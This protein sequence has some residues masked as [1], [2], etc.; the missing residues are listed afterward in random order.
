MF[1]LGINGSPRKKGNSQYLM[2]LF[3]R[4]MEGKGYETRVLDATKLDINAC[5]GC[6]TCEK[7][8]DC[9]FKDEFTTLFLPEVI[10][11]DII[12]ISSPVYF[13]AFP[14]KLTALIDRTQVLWSRKYRLKK[15]DYKDR[16]RKGV[17]LAVGATKGKDLFDGMD[18]TVRYFFDAADIK[19]DGNLFFRGVD[20]K[21]EMGK[22]DR[23]HQDIKLLCEKY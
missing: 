11:A 7:K 6:G 9:M 2:S 19:Y 21:G 5:I 3:I 15:N 4:E 14:S 12:V 8:G 22:H 17:L 18:L 20:E 10:R 13:Y 16:D 1:V 23:V